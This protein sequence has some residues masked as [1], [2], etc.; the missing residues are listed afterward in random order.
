MILVM[1]KDKKNKKTQLIIIAMFIFFTIWWLG[2]SL[3][4]NFRQHSYVL[5]SEVYGLIALVGGLNGLFI[6]RGLGGH[7]SYFGKAIIFLAIGLLLQEFGQLAYSYMNSIAKIAVPYPSYP[8]IGF[9]GSIPMYIAGAYNLSKGLSV[10]SIVRKAPLKLFASIL[11]SA[12][13]VATSYWLF[14]KGYS[15]EGK[16]HITVFFDFGYPLGQAIYVSIALMIL[17]SVRGLLGGLMKKPILL[18]LLAFLVQYTADSNFL[19]QTIHETWG[20][21]GYGDYIYMTAYVLMSLSLILLCAPIA[22]LRKSSSITT[23]SPTQQ[24]STEGA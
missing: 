2:M 17:L 4:H 13:I 8:D 11:A 18:L 6:A 19:Y 14:L 5:L 21:A 3:S 7:R 16:S 15:T 10:G 23:D 12:A 1:L 22:G 9:F 24:T 20:P